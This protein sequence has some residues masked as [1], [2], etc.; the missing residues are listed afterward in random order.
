MTGSFCGKTFFKEVYFL[1][2][3]ALFLLLPGGVNAAL[4]YISPSTDAL[5]IGDNFTVRIMLDTSGQKVN[6]AEAVLSF[7]PL[8]LRV[9]TMS[10]AG[11]IFNFWPGEPVYSNASGS[12]SFAGGSSKD[13]VGSFGQI[14]TVTFEAR[15]AGTQ[16]LEFRS[17]AVLRSDGMGTNIIET[18]NSGIYTVSPRSISPEPIFVPQSANAPAP[19]AVSSG[20]HP[21]QDRWYALSTVELSWQ[22]PADVT[23]IRI[24]LNK[25]PVSIPTINYSPPI[26]ERLM[27]GIEDGTWYFHIQMRNQSGWGNITHYRINIDTE[28]P[29][30]FNIREP[31]RLDLTDPRLQFEF[32]SADFT[33]GIKHYE[34]QLNDGAPVIWVDDGTGIYAIPA[35]PPGRHTI[36]A[37]AVDGAGN[38]L[39]NTLTF[40]IEALDPPV[41]TDYPHSLSS[42]SVLVV[43]GETYPNSRVLIWLQEERGEPVNHVVESDGEGKFV[44]ISPD[45]PRNGL[46]RMW[47]E[48]V[49]ERGARS[50]R[51][52]E[53][54]FVVQPPGIMRIGSLALNVLSVVTPLFGLLVL[55]VMSFIYT[56]HKWTVTRR[57][58]KKEIKEAEISLHQAFAILRDEAAKNTHL[59]DK[60]SERRELTKEEKIIRERMKKNLDAVETMVEKEILDIEEQL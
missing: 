46:Y 48:V 45:K 18:M 23:A 8:D 41:L 28:K 52:T 3:S 25:E 42:G 22:V 44:F 11:S 21:D 20:T 30:F 38:Y 24:L 12:I 36:I 51:S 2:L 59:L 10:S 60:V 49:D 43:R 37:K 34:V 40:N 1:L 16:R 17:G 6:A 9:V 19:P 39:V 13:Y 29:E 50:E 15:R 7:D 27:E 54:V 26:N 32:D 47:A 14:L 35:L 5:V 31:E 58:L 4:L 55:L 56:E 57:R 33:S 53:I